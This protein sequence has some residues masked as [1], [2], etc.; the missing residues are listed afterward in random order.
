MFREG[1]VLSRYVVPQD[2]V[3]QDHAP[4]PIPGL[5]LYNLRRGC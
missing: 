4:A 1:V 5:D 3:L 2:V